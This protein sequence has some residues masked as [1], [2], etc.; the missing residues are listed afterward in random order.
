MSG[1][2]RDRVR[3]VVADL[4]GTLLHG[5]DTFEGRFITQRSVETIE[6]LHD[7]GYLFAIAT[8]RP[9][10]TGLAF[11]ER[12]PADVVVYLNGALIDLNKRK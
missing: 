10:S 12:L 3:L 7:A 5:A 1:A 11:A 2:A 9:V 6:R 4:D 8:A